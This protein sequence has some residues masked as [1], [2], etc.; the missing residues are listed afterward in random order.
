MRISC[1]VMLLIGALVQ[2][3][4]SE[5]SKSVTH[6]FD[7]AGQGSTGSSVI[8]PN[9]QAPSF[10]NLKLRSD[11]EVLHSAN[12]RVDY[13]GEN[14]EALQSYREEVISDGRS[15]YSLKVIESLIPV[16][17]DWEILRRVR[18]GF[19][20]RY[21]DFELR[22][23]MLADQNFVITSDLTSFIIAG[24]S[25]DHYS[26]T[27]KRASGNSYEVWVDSETGLVLRSHRFDQNGVLRFSREHENLNQMP[28]LSRAIWFQGAHDERLLDPSKALEGQVGVPVF[29]PRQVPPGYQLLRSFQLSASDGLW[30]KL[31]YT[32]GIEPLFML[33]RPTPL[34]QGPK[35]PKAG[36]FGQNNPEQ[37]QSDNRLMVFDQDEI[38]A[39]QIE[40]PEGIFE[41][42][43][44]IHLQELMDMLISA[45][46]SE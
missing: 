14:G 22:D 42:V 38:S 13:F 12:C 10:R 45:L 17:S 8:D 2:G 32:N 18:E 19:S 6:G 26:I 36:D 7:T 34:K 37:S 40:L 25:C 23:R 31:V 1:K 41:V 16:A 28:D 15:K 9:P 21:G 35:G 39:A 4:G 5:S 24:Q 29:I 11:Q 46:P 30:L 44:S 3:C 33:E 20:F 27:P 43:G